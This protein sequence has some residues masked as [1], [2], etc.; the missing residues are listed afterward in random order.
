LPRSETN[1]IFRVTFREL[2]KALALIQTLPEGPFQTDQEAAAA[3]IRSY[4]YNDN[5]SEK[6]LP[7]ALFD[8]RVRLPIRAM[9]ENGSEEEL[10]R[11]SVLIAAEPK[12]A[13]WLQLIKS[14]QSG[15]VDHIGA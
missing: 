2:E 4:L 1:L 7:E 12:A 14:Y 9:K 6:D 10:E 11:L 3:L 13:P 5:L 8:E 15:N